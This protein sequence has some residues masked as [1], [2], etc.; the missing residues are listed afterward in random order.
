MSPSP[1]WSIFVGD[2]GSASMSEAANAILGLSTSRIDED[3]E[4]LI[5]SNGFIKSL[6]GDSGSFNDPG[7]FPWDH[8]QEVMSNCNS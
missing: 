2:S 3:A 6:V 7:S 8:F 1:W 5:A 4:L